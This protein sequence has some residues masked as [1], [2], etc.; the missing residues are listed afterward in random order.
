MSG[1][2]LP[3]GGSAGF[4]A[5]PRRGS[6]LTTLTDAD[7]VARPLSLA[8][9]LV[10]FATLSAFAMA[11]WAR[12]VEPSSAG[13]LALALAPVCAGALLLRALS[14]RR[15]GRTTTLLGSV[16]AVV[17]LVAALLAAGLPAHLL[18][19]A[20]WGAL[21]EQIQGGIG[22]IEQAQL[23]YTGTDPWIRL[24]LVLGA[25]ALAALAAA[26]AFW[27]ARNRGRLRA[28]GL[29]ALLIAY[30]TGATLDNPG[31]EALWG[32]VLLVLAVAWLWVPG[33]RPGRR[34]PAISVALGVGV[35]ALPLAAKLNGPAWWEYQNWSWFGA[36][37]TVSFQWNHDY[38]P[39]DWPRNGTTVMTVETT[40]P[41]Y[42]KA[43]VLD[44]FDG[45]RWGRATPGDPTATAEL[46]A[47]GA[48]P[49]AGL[50][51]RHRGW[52]TEANFEFQ[53]LTSDL[54]IGAGVP[55]AVNGLDGTLES[56]DGTLTRVGPALERGEQYSIVTYVPEPI[57]AQLRRAPVARSVRRFGGS[58]LLGVPWSSASAHASLSAE[59]A[60]RM[61]LW[62]EHDPRATTRLL[63]S[64]YAD[65]Y[66]LALEWVSGARTPYD[67]VRAI[68]G[69]LR[70]DYAY[71]PTVPEHAYPLSSFLFADGAGYCQQFAGSM[72]LMLRM[73]GIPSRVVSGFAP[74]SLDTSTGTYQVHD[75]DAHSW[76]EVYFRGIGWV[77][78]DPTPAAAPAES[79]RL[80]GEFATA[81]RGPAP[82]PTID[83]ATGQSAGGRVPASTPAATATG[84]GPWVAIGIGV[85]LGAV[86]LTIAG[87]AIAWRRRRRLVQGA[88][89]EAQIA[90]LRDALERVGWKLEP[91][92]TL[93]AIERRATGIAR[94]GIR[95]YAASLRSYRYAPAAG[96]PPGPAERRALRRALAGAGPA[97]RLRA[98]LAIPPGGPSRA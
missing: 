92:T 32:L 64:P 71:T 91:R 44:R 42:W 59:P 53:A 70:H 41:L 29:A 56:P 3:A 1:T 76:V 10:L 80:G 9:E 40:R 86:A 94:A 62:G 74:G 36:T 28:A 72:G 43:S 79:Q 65:T 96:S 35:L 26:L 6:R 78:F 14:F 24:S 77:T 25:P 51:R 98:L 27:P 61:P 19:P 31:A 30:G 5:P 50:E 23:P 17:T 75:F 12:L 95:G 97:R 85:L 39:L 55:D 84:G 47:R 22:G 60:I 16:V 58:T 11:Q 73:V 33:L 8:V 38:G 37:R 18:A 15:P 69:H 90:E 54:V 4:P 2:A 87:G 67:A 66:R 68:E 49:G 89:V 48:I 45:Y 13:R 83:P 57:P 34:G 20:H 63:N 88:A 7:E 52:V 93:L 46:T 81:F 21:R 82:N